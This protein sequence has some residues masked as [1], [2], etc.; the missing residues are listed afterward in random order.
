L[1]Y[2][3]QNPGGPTQQGFIDMPFGETFF[4]SPMVGYSR[5]RVKSI[6]NSS[7]KLIKSG[8]GTQETEFYTSKDFPYRADFTDFDPK[9]NVRFKSDPIMRFLKIDTREMITLS[10]GFRVIINDMNGKVKSQASYPESDPSNVINYTKYVYRI[11]KL[12]ENSYRLNNSLPVV[13]KTAIVTDKEIGKDVEMMVDFREHKSETNSSGVHFNL[14]GFFAGIWIPTIPVLFK[15]PMHD[16]NTFRS[17]SMLKVINQYGIVDSVIQIDK[18][19]AVSTKN[20]VYDSET[21]D[22]IVSRTQN[23]FNDPLYNTSYPAHWYY[24]GMEP[25]Y[26][27]IDVRYDKVV[28]RNGFIE[29]SF[30]NQ[31]L[32]ESGDEIYVDD[33]KNK[34]GPPNTVGCLVV[35]GIKNLPKSNEFKIW[36]LDLRKDFRNTTKQFIFIDKDGNPYNSLGCSIKIIRSGKRNILS[37]TINSITSLTNPLKSGSISFSVNDNVINASAV[38]FKDKWKGEQSFYTNTVYTNVV[39]QAPI[40]TITRTPYQNIFV[41]YDRFRTKFDGWRNTWYYRYNP[42]FIKSRGWDN[43]KKVNT[44]D[45]GAKS[46]IFFNLDEITTSHQI[47]S[48]KLA[49][50]SHGH[51]I[52]VPVTHGLSG[53]GGYW[54][55]N[56]NPH[57]SAA[58]HSNAFIV[59]RL[60]SP[61]WGDRQDIWQWFYENNSGDPYTQYVQP[62]TYPQGGWNNQSYDN[63]SSG[64]N[65]LVLTNM[66]KQ[67]IID[68]Y[69]KNYTTAFQLELAPHYGGYD[70][71]RVCFSNNA[72]LEVK[73]YDCAEAFG[74]PGNPSAPLPGQ[75]VANCVNKEWVTYCLSVFNRSFMNPYCHGILGNWRNERSYV[76]YSDRNETDPNTTTNIK[77]DGRIKNFVPYWKFLGNALTKSN[78]PNW[79]WNSE[80]TQFNR[81]GFEIENH[82]PLDR[83]NAGLYGYN[84]NLPTAVVNNSR[85]QES[86]FDGFEDYTYKDRICAGDCKPERE[87]WSR[88]LKWTNFNNNLIVNTTAHSGASSLKVTSGSFVETSQTVSSINSGTTPDI[89][90]GIS[91]TSSTLTGINFDGTGLTGYY[92]SETSNNPAYL[93][94]VRVDRL[95]NIWFGHKGSCN[96]GDNNQLPPQL[97]GKCDNLSIT[98]KG[99]ILFPVAGNYRFYFETNDQIEFYLNGAIVPASCWGNNSGYNTTNC[100]SIQISAS[101][102]EVKTIELRFVQYGGMGG[103]RFM[104]QP[105]GA[106]NFLLVPTSN[107]YP[108]GTN[109]G[110]IVSS[111]TFWCT[112]P[113]KIQAISNAMIDG[114]QLS[115]GKKMVL[116]AWIKEDGNANGSTYSNNSIQIS[117]DGNGSSVQNFKS[118]GYIIEGW[119]RYE[120][121][122][123]IPASAVSIQVK[124]KNNNTNTNSVYFDDVRIHPYNANMKSFV[125]HPKTLRLMAELDENNYCS[126]YEYDDDGTLTR[127]KKE[128]KEGIKTIKETRGSIQR[129]IQTIE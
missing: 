60:R 45:Y 124:L 33:L 109:A 23:E 94:A 69:A 98:W 121:V 105:P 13:G 11:E 61:F 17:V 101:Q 51:F 30:V 32:F 38:E 7:N 56:S 75:Q 96:K 55:N 91:K 125:Y 48:A 83:Y 53:Y 116:S 59:K 73:Y 79:V 67:M 72:E 34:N 70:E 107:L 31:N 42:D 115:P 62:Q 35:T 66:V 10:Q 2:E 68:K 122:F 123:V 46:W 26:Q 87:N 63:F 28:F 43:G 127:V 49:L 71:A 36:A 22:V 111:Q 117:Y 39:R 14:D 58:G 21:G 6:H 15:P 40:R 113:T 99:K 126:F 108:D 77:S 24:S 37:A 88:H 3:N 19:S 8:V 78:D 80:I 25:A 1:N 44:R 118:T 100:T 52:K 57:A 16:E 106:N 89:N 18:G 64:D 97:G 104:W 110:A 120:C 4:P 84:D 50:R 9:S 29:S 20:L 119:Q 93:K 54:H 112:Q 41:G 103:T 5:V 27:N 102:Y 86:G 76:F 92:Y 85:Y 12:G 47:I 82:D 74:L 114:F 65:R 95:I 128:T 129:N 81:K 90:I